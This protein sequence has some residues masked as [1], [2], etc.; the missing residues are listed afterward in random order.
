MEVPESIEIDLIKRPDLP[1]DGVCEPS[2][3]SVPGGGI[4]N[5]VFDAAGVRI[6]L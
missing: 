4:A 5:A 6:R 1:L 3:V 2:L